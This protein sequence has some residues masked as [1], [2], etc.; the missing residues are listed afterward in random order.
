MQTFPHPRRVSFSY[1]S[2][3]HENQFDRRDGWTRGYGTT[4]PDLLFAD[5]Y[6]RSRWR[7]GGDGK[8]VTLFGW[9][10][11]EEKAGGTE[12]EQ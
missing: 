2:C 4:Y 6:M 8:G 7:G 1:I 12:K 10:E 9:V 3:C 11:E 5:A